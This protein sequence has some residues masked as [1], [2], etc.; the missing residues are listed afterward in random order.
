LN[1]KIGAIILAAGG[2]RRLGKPKQL[3]R[4][5]GKTLVRRI[6]E[7][8]ESVPCSPV[9]LVLGSQAAEIS[10][11]A[12]GTLCLIASNPDWQTGMGTSIR[13]GLRAAL[14]AQPALDALLLVVCDQYVVT[15]EI[16]Q[17]LVKA[18]MKN[19]HAI[20][21]SEY[22]GTIGVPAIFDR[23]YFDELLTLP[24]DSGAKSII[25]KNRAYVGSVPFPEGA[26]DIDSLEDVEKLST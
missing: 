4:Y 13:A 5:A 14:A 26:L 19:N 20:M 6:I 16:L 17:M 10:R 3:V 2:S 25:L 21:A 18:R 24:D 1:E 9:V 15:T 23:A 7:A 12:D 11:E 8:T 22:S